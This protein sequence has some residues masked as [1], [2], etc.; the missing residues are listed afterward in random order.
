M[1]SLFLPLEDFRSLYFAG[2]GIAG[3][4]ENEGLYPSSNLIL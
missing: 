2:N 4:I 3:C 1:L